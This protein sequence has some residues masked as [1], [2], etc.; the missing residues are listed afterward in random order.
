MTDKPLRVG[1]IGCGEW[2]RWHMDV[3]PHLP[4]L[5]VR[6]YADINEAAAQ[7]F[8]RKYGG[9]Y[10]TTDPQHVFDDPDIDFVMICTWHNTH[11]PLTVAAAA[12]GKHIFLEKPMALTLADCRAIGETV[13]RAGVQMVLGYKFR[14]APYVL[15]ARE[16]LPRPLLT[17]GQIMD[18]RWADEG[19]FQDP[20]IGGGNVLSQG[21]HIF[22]L[23][24]YLHGREPVRV[25]AAGGALT[26]PGNPLVDTLAASITFADGSIASAVAADAGPAPFTSKFFAQT[27]GI[28]KSAT[29]S[30]RCQSLTTADD[31]KVETCTINDLDD[32]GR[33]SPEGMVQQLREFARCLRAGKPSAISVGPREGFRAT[34]LALAAIEAARTGQPQ[35]VPKL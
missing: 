12:A 20:V 10:A 4:E 28:Q 5:R 19:W 34:A 18:L 1:M 9:D 32:A 33:A 3:M 15:R 30:A 11:R 23:V 16:F 7:S 24:C 27:F 2:G 31:G 21:C 29:L 14:F 22:D 17:V 13:A 26:H 25:A 35:V 8:L 6:G